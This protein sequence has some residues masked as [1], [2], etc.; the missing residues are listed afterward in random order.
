MEVRYGSKRL[1]RICLDE[2]ECK[3]AYSK[4]FGK[5]ALRHN[6]LETATSMSDLKVL[7]PGGK[8]HPL[9]GGREGQWAG[10]L[11]GNYR[12]IVEPKVDGLEVIA[13]EQNV[14]T[15]IDIKDYH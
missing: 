1:E 12:M 9:H 7:D 4:L 13:V 14:V 11:S 10:S 15:V 6:A 5:I 3:K 8:W 2:R